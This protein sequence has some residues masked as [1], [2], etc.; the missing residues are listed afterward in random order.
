[1]GARHRHAVATRFC[2]NPLR[3]LVAAN[4]AENIGDSMS[5]DVNQCKK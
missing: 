3:Q 2:D 4:V 5:G 1:M